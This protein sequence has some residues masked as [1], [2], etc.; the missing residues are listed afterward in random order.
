MDTVRVFIVDDA[1]VWC[2]G[3]KTIL[4]TEPGFLVV[5]TTGSVA[6][7][8]VR[9]PALRPKVLIL[10]IELASGDGLGL[11]RALAEAVPEMSI[12]VMT[13]APAEEMACETL[14]A[15]AKGYLSKR[16]APS[17]VVRA[18]RAVARGQYVLEPGASKSLVSRLRQGES[19]APTTASLSEREIEVL[20][21]L[22]QGCSNRAIAE[23]LFVSESTVRFH[24]H[25][26]LQKLGCKNRTEAVIEGFR[27]GILGAPFRESAVSLS[28][29]AAV[30]RVGQ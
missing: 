25:H 1:P 7:A 27:L 16:S 4:S 3:L 19:T 15:G 13:M 22:A 26:L 29:R 20:E 23:K 28:R 18:V 2:E 10:E 21:L 5:G 30:A 6:E 11:C 8:R 9:V 14:A 24:V 17:E 12:L